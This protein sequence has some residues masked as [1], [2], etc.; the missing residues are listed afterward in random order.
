MKNARRIF[1]FISCTIML[2]LALVVTPHISNA[3][4]QPKT[5][6]PPTMMQI[7]STYSGYTYLQS[8]T[9]SIKDN[10]NQTA[11][12]TASTQAKMNVG[13]IGA[14]IQLQE[15]TGATWVDVGTL[16]T[17][18]STN[19]SYFQKTASKTTR[20][21][22]YYRARVTH[23]VYNEGVTEQVIEYTDNMLA[24]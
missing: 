12:I 2:V 5:T 13:E 20:S 9:R 1:G 15:W 19:T 3:A 11:D 14:K 22:Y 21:G 10:S 4:T 23:Y 18:S 17:L 16:T 8:S 6:P 24:S 7:Q